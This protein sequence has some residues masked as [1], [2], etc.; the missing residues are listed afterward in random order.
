MPLTPAHIGPAVLIGALAGRKL[1]LAVLITSTVLIDLEVLILGFERG[2]FIYHGFFHTFIG[3]TFFGL[4]FGMIVF[5]LIQFSWKI[6][7]FFYA[8]NLK[9]RRFREGLSHSWLFSYKCITI[10]AIIGAYSHIALDWLF[11]DDI[12]IM[13]VSDANFFYDYSSHF[14]SATLFTVY[15]LCLVSFLIGLALYKYRSM[16]DKNKWY[17]T[18]NLFDFKPHKK[19]L[20]GILGIISTPFAISGISIYLVV[21]FAL[22]L[23]FWKVTHPLN[24]IE[25]DGLILIWGIVPILT[26]IYGYSKALKIAN[27]K[28]IE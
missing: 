4:I 1:N 18:H 3:A 6:K 10:S 25:S 27:W 5:L 19:D 22:N 15:F 17:N 23:P 12:R 28:L 24:I 20:W 7:D 14:F 8:D 11:Y 21:I 26:M 13:I 16:S 9:Y 2:L